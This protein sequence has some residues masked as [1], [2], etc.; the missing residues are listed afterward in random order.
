MPRPSQETAILDAALHCFATMGYDATRTR[1]IAEAAG[2]SEGALYRHYPS[3][4]A[5]AQA[6]FLHHMQKYIRR[7]QDIVNDQASVEQRL[8]EIIAG[9]LAMYRANPD[10]IVFIL[11][12]RPRLMGTLPPDMPYP[13][14]VVEALMREGQSKEVLRSGEPLLLASIFMGCFLRPIIVS[15]SGLHSTLDL[16]HDTQ[17][18]QLITDAAWTAVARSQ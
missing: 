16:S 3:K 1:H 6:L 18:D 13:I 5:I 8:R 10:A 9:S 15:R 11:L 14:A 4:E 17:H 2:V 12:E 7:L